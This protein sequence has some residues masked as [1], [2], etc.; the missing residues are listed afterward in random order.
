M[1]HS[2]VPSEPESLEIQAHEAWEAGRLKEAFRLFKHAVDL[3][4]TECLLN[5]GYFHDTGIGTREDKGEAMRCYKLAY[6]WGV[7]AAASNIAVLYR[8]Q[9]KPRLMFAW[10][11]R[12]ADM[13]DGDAQL[14]FAKCLLDGRGVRRSPTDAK[15]HLRRA[16]TSKLITLDA[17][18]EAHALLGQLSGART[19]RAG[20]RP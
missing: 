15:R 19:H 9:G 4:A 3:G 10:Y 11:R 20:A 16:A 17:R 14:E 2:V 6:R 8:E 13:G 7:S 1:M 12:A 18:N 5:L